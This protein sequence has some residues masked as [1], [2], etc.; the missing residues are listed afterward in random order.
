MLAFYYAFIFFFFFHL[1][2]VTTFSQVLFQEDSLALNIIH[3]NCEWKE[4]VK[5][6]E[7]TYLNW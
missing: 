6:M 1:S 5:S 2:I 4:E 3:I 7:V